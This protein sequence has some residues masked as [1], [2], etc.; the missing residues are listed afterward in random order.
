[1][2]L[3]PLW[4]FGEH[5]II[6][7]RGVLYDRPRSIPPQ[8]RVRVEEIAETTSEDSF[9]NLFLAEQRLV[10]SGEISLPPDR[11]IPGIHQAQCAV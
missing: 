5:K 1:V 3:Y 7:M 10:K 2:L 4:P 9:R 6:Q 11:V 8:V